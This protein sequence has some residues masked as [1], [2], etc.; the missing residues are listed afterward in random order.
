MIFKRQEWVFLSS[1]VMLV[2][3]KV[4]WPTFFPTNTSKP[5]FFGLCAA[6]GISQT[7][8]GRVWWEWEDEREHCLLFSSLGTEQSRLCEDTC[9]PQKRLTA[10]QGHLY[11][12]DAAESCVVQRSWNI[13][14]TFLIVRWHPQYT[15]I[16]R[17]TLLLCHVLTQYSKLD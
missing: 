3:V 15:V 6:R 8:R 7:S 5:A 13:C 12:C 14:N 11:L 9:Y 1:L 16:T 10:P 17:V 2:V 4:L